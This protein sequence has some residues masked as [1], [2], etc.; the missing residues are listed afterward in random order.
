MN[1][2]AGHFLEGTE[3]TEFD[4]AFFNINPNEAKVR[5][6]YFMNGLV[7]YVDRPWTLGSE[8]IWKEPMKPSRM[9]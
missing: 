2:K 1:V 9:V 3:Y 7:I 4:A 5:M 6:D 8:C